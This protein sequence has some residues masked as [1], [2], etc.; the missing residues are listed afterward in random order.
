[1]D[2]AIN[3]EVAM[4]RTARRTPAFEGMEGRVLL[5]S[6]MRDPAAHVYRSQVSTGHFV[7]NGTLVGIPY[8]T[9]SQDGIV[10]TAFPLSGRVKSMHK[11]TGSLLLTDPIISPGRQPDLSNATLT[12][13]NARGTVQIKTAESPSNRHVFIVT[14]GSG[15]YA[16]V[17]G[18]G[19][20]IITYNQRMHEYQIALH[21]AVG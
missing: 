10:V 18:S 13:S 3:K 19:M 20:A 21:S 12:L 14:Y 8:G 5:S 6:G 2:G 7:L 9:V 15:A 11:V 1:V 17:Y 16:S 4:S